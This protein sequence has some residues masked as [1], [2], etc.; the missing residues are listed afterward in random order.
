MAFCRSYSEKNGQIQ[1]YFLTSCVIKC[2]KV[3]SEYFSLYSELTETSLFRSSNGVLFLYV[4][5]ALGM[6][7]QMSLK[8]GRGHSEGQWSGGQMS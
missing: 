7:F 6:F 3:K 4:L 8:M 1:L 5:S 2:I